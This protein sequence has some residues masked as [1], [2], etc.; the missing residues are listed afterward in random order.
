[1]P[2]FQFPTEIPFSFQDVRNEFDRLLDRVWHVGLNTAP[3][4]GQDWAPSIDVVDAGDSYHV[5]LEV[6]GM[7]ADQ[8]EVSILSNSLL[9]RGCKP[10]PPKP[11]EGQRQ[12]RAECRYGSF[13][14]KYEFPMPVS[15]DGIG[16]AC[17]HGVLDITVPKKPEA[18]GRSIKVTPQE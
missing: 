10:S 18:R 8:V 16:A 4:D 12:I 6:P 2:G 9:I 5:R 1:M 7:S 3:L 17:K 13:S 15:E 11:G 14:R